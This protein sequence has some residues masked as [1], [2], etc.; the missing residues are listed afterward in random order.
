MAIDLALRLAV[1]GGSRGFEHLLKFALDVVDLDAILRTLRSGHA[2]NDAVQIEIKRR[3]VVD[4][5]T[6]RH[7]EQTLRLEVAAQRIDL[8]LAASGHE[9]VAASFFVDREE[10]HRGAILRRHVRDRG[11]IGQR[12]RGRAVAEELDELADHLRLAQHLGDGEHEVGRGD[13]FAQ[14]A[15]QMHADDIRR[16]ESRP[17][18][19]ACPLPPRSRRRPSRRCRGR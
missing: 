18:A 8:R 1:A 16:Q 15:C 5:A 14:R 17:A 2:G 6:L 13:A 7:P 4:V 19:R 11:A 9:H 10:A 3:R 12:Q